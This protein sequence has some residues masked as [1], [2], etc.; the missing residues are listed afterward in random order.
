MHSGEKGSEAEARSL[1]NKF[2]GAQLLVNAID[3][4]MAANSGRS[5]TT[6]SNLFV[7]FLSR[8]RYARDKT[9]LRNHSRLP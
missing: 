7:L 6:V 8:L 4:L 3:P 9:F 2:L 5:A 1:L